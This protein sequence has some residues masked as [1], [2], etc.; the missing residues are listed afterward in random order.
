MASHVRTDG[1]LV[2]LLWTGSVITL[3]PHNQE[4]KALLD[5]GFTADG[6]KTTVSIAQQDAGRDGYGQ[7]SESYQSV[8]LTLS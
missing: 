6:A 5:A 3:I 2:Q 8:K 4:A 1:A 7:T